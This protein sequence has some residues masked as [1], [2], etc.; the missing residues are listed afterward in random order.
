MM[1][2]IKLILLGVS[3]I[4]ILGM[5]WGLDHLYNKVQDQKTTID[6]ME[7]KNEAI[8]QVAVT[9]INRPRTDDDVTSRLCEWAARQYKDETGE[10]LQLPNG[11]C[12]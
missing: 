9:A 12:N 5:L 6:T 10:K 2:K 3:V 1:S 11:P 4:G 8:K 7:K